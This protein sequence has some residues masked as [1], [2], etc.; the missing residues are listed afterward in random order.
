MPRQISCIISLD[1]IEDWEKV[2][3]LQQDPEDEA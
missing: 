1:G 2:Q 3:K